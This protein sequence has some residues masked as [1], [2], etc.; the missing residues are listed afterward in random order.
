MSDVL[1][2]S[3][4]PGWTSVDNTGTVDRLT[5]ASAAG[6]LESDPATSGKDQSSTIGVTE[7]LGRARSAATPYLQHLTTLVQRIFLAPERASNP[8]RS[9]VFAAVDTREDS[10]LLAAAAAELVASRVSGRVCLVDANFIAPSLHRCYGLTNELGLVDALTG[11]GP[12][13]SYARRLIQGH[14][15]SLWLLPSGAS[16][17]SDGLLRSEAAQDRIRDLIEAFDYLIIAA[18]AATRYHTARVLGAQADGIVLITEA[19]VTRRR[20]VRACADVLR[21]AGGCILG[22][23][24]TNRTFP[25]PEAVYRL[26]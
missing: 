26:L 25:I 10:A 12:V 11:S 3:G 14:D 2:L 4:A 19:N 8:I 13:R 24:L 22:T 1:Q 23:V 18:P 6:P 17:A 7:R 16:D 21:T 15:S 5:P 9:V 20:A